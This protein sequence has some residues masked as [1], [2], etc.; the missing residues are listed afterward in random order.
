MVQNGWDSFYL[1]IGQARLHIT[2]TGH[3][4]GKPTL[5]LLHGHTDHGQCWT[6]LARDYAARFNCVMPDMVGHGQSSRLT[7][8]R[9]LNTMVAEISSLLYMLGLDEVRVIGHSMGAHLA[10]MLAAALPRKVKAIVLEDPPWFVDQPRE[11]LD[12]QSERVQQIVRDLQRWQGM[13]HAQLMA[14]RAPTVN[15]DKT[16]LAMWAQARQ[17]AD[18]QLLGGL[19]WHAL[20]EW[21]QTLARID[22][23]TLL[24]TGGAEGR[25][26]DEATLQRAVEIAPAIDHLHFET[27]DHHINR[28]CHTQYSEAVL[29]WLT[30]K[31]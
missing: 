22:C 26:V 28:S 25:I 1:D 2:C 4:S 6:T 7:D 12:P 16:N 31:E 15:W 21:E 24:I 29:T 10:A 27:A 3:G 8:R 17:Q 14:E 20:L 5:L 19:Q 23:P 11:I 9:T 13:T 30:E 18:V